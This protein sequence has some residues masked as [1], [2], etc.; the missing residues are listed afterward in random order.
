M[1]SEC[2]MDSV[3]KINIQAQYVCTVSINI[4]SNFYKT[5]QI[6]TTYRLQNLFAVY[7][8]YTM[9]MLEQVT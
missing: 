4:Q 9:Y 6:K 3:T 7:A 5:A 2:F 8:K 1:D